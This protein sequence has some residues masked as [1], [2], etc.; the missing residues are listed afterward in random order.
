VCR[1]ATRG[2]QYGEELAKIGGNLKEKR[3]L[4]LNDAEAEAGKYRQQR[5]V[6]YE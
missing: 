6:H 2:K 3:K 5:R 4:K 1:Y